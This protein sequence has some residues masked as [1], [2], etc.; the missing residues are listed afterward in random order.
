MIEIHDQIRPGKTQVGVL[1]R[2]WIVDLSKL[3]STEGELG[4]GT[5]QNPKKRFRPRVTLTL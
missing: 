1:V 5:T 4:P 2:S 3:R